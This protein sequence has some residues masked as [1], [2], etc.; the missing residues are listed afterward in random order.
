MYRFLFL[1]ITYYVCK[2]RGK[3]SSANGSIRKILEKYADI[4]ATPSRDVVDL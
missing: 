4:S 2:A 1:R 3:N